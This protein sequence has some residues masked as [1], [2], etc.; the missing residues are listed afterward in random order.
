MHIGLV[1]MGELKVGDEV[2]LHID[3]VGEEEDWVDNEDGW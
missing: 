3:E 2:S 1:I